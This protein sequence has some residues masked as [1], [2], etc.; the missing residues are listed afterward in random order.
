MPHVPLPA[1]DAQVGHQPRLPLGMFGADRFQAGNVGI[2]HLTRRVTQLAV[3]GAH[4][5][6]PFGT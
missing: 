6:C 4:P 2:G 3:A 1:P 5:H